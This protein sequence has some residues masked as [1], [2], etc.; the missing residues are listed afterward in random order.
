[1]RRFSLLGTLPMLA[2]GM[3]RAARAFGI[4]IL[5]NTAMQREA[6][7]EQ[8]L[9][10][11]PRLVR[12]VKAT[13]CDSETLTA[14]VPGEGTHRVYELLAQGT[15][16]RPNGAQEWMYELVQNMCAAGDW[17]TYNT[18][19]QAYL[20]GASADDAALCAGAHGSL[21]RSNA[22]L[23]GGTCPLVVCL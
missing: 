8:V 10:L 16:R 1:M 5:C 3:E 9:L 15:D 19:M 4:D 12:L 20:E 6:E 2:C 14:A 22:R 11:V 21:L 17:E 7:H 23:L 18:A 13:A